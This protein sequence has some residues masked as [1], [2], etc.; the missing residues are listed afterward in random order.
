[1]L[2]VGL[3]DSDIYQIFPATADQSEVAGD[4]LLR[5]IVQQ[6]MVATDDSYITSAVQ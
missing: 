5:E 2:T 6:I 1:M 4:S 3:T